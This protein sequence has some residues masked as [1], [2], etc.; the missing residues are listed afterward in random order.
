MKT[1]PAQIAVFMIASFLSIAF[2]FWMLSYSEYET[3]R[4]AGT[5]N[6]VEVQC[7]LCEIN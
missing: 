5:G 7:E 1:N 2:F 6:T 3:A 4:K